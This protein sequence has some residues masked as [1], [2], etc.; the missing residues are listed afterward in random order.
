MAGE[1]ARRGAALATA[2]L[3]ALAGMAADLDLLV[4][5][6]RGQSHSLGAAFI[7]GGVAWA[8]MRARSSGPR[9]RLAAAVAAAYASHVLL[10]WLGSDSRPPIGIMALWPFSDTYSESPLHLFLAISRRYW[11]TEFWTYNLR[12][13][14]REVL[15]LGPIVAAVYLLRRPSLTRGT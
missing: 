8:A 1:P 10:D 14:A 11:L 5:G 2:G 13:L 4:G 12:A 15:I 9:L 7:A 3:Y 6:H